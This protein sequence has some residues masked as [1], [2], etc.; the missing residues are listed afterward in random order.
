MGLE[1]IDR[2][3]ERYLPGEHVKAVLDIFDANSG[4]TVQ[5]GDHG[6]VE[7]GK[8]R[9]VTG[10]VRVWWGGFAFETSADNLLPVHRPPNRGE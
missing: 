1:Q 8:V 7:D 5:E 3:F 9:G 2:L 4:K 6:I 10:L